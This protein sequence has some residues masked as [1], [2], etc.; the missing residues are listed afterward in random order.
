LLPSIIGNCCTKPKGIILELGLL[1]HVTPFVATEMIAAN[2]FS[3]FCMTHKAIKA[4][5]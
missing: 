3:D 2:Q 5:F 1:P 4:C